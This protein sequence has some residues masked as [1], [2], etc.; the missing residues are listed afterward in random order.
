MNRTA[1]EKGGERPK[2][3]GSYDDREVNPDCIKNLGLSPIALASV[4]QEVKNSGKVVR[5]PFYENTVCSGA[6]N[7]V[8]V[9]FDQ[10]SFCKWA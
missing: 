1:P 7:F 6:I 9:V 2:K 3:C 4:D 10:R 8:D 5:F